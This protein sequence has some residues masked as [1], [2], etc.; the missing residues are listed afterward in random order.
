MHHGHFNYNLW[1]SCSVMC[2]IVLQQTRFR[3]LT[4]PPAPSSSALHLLR[5]SGY[6]ASPRRPEVPLPGVAPQADECNR[7]RGYLGDRDDGGPRAERGPRGGS[8]GRPGG[9]VIDFGGFPILAIRSI[10]ATRVYSFCPYGSDP[11]DSDP[12][13]DIISNSPTLL[14]FYADM[15]HTMVRWPA[16]Y[17]GQRT[18]HGG[19]VL[20]IF[21]RV[22]PSVFAVRCATRFRGRLVLLYRVV[23]TGLQSWQA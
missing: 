15:G 17:T 4:P 23:E 18:P 11:A 16:L 6:F 5:A 2:A 10:C 14:R 22:P 19:M 21:A 7:E 8:A 1:A 13:V 20:V 9:W 3:A 12:P